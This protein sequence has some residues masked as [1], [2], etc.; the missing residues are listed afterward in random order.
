MCVQKKEQYKIRERQVG[1]G[2]GKHTTAD[3]VHKKE[4]TK[5][6]FLC[7]C[8]CMCMKDVF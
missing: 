8:M 2:M 5:L 3:S 7:V 1:V 6:T 4:V